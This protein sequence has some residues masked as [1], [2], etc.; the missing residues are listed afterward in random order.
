[1]NERDLSF[2]IFF[3]SSNFIEYETLLEEEFLNDNRIVNSSLEPMLLKCL[4][5]THIIYMKN[6][7]LDNEMNRK[8]QENE[9]N[10]KNYKCYWLVRSILLFYHLIYVLL[11]NIISLV[12]L[13]TTKSN[14]KKEKEG[15]VKSIGSRI[16]TSPLIRYIWPSSKTKEHLRKRTK[17]LVTVLYNRNKR[18]SKHDSLAL[19]TSLL[20]D[21]VLVIIIIQLWGNYLS[22]DLL[23][24]WCIS[25]N[26]RISSFIIWLMESGSRTASP[27]GIKLNLQLDRTFAYMLLAGFDWWSDVCSLMYNITMAAFSIISPSILTYYLRPITL[28]VLSL[29][30][31]SF[32][33]SLMCDLL[34]FI[35]LHISLFYLMSARI[36]HIQLSILITLWRLFRGQKR[37]VLRNNR[38]DSFAIYTAATRNSITHKKIIKAGGI[39]LDQVILGS[40]LFIILAILFPTLSIFYSSLTAFKL[41]VNVLYILLNM[42]QKL[43]LWTPWF[44]LIHRFYLLQACGMQSLAI[45]SIDF[46]GN[47]DHPV[48]FYYRLCGYCNGSVWVDPVFNEV[49]YKNRVLLEDYCSRDFFI[50]IFKGERL[51]QI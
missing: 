20:L 3:Y 48:N 51:P 12:S 43:L 5:Y 10:D 46:N 32:I 40:L 4:K 6:K 37:N 17:Q 15:T 36:Y 13:I 21:S 31:L 28:I 1:M 16:L 11:V 26:S 42:V 27:L 7:Y 33:C 18:V 38:I 23:V 41:C 2:H 50:K 22:M 9:S 34:A 39:T 25:V 47:I 49:I 44:H 14:K 8:M 19:L 45:V 29:F 30:G 24:Q 35:S